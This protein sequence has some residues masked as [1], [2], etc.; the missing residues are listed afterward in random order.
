MCEAMSTW[1]QFMPSQENHG[2][3][4]KTWTQVTSVT[5][6]F[7]FKPTIIDKGGAGH[8]LTITTGTLLWFCCFDSVLQRPYSLPAADI[9]NNSSI[10]PGNSTIMK[11]T[12][13]PCTQ[14]EF[15]TC[16][17]EDANG[18]NPFSEIPPHSCRLQSSY[19]ARVGHTDPSVQD[20][21]TG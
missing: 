20:I 18:R 13:I 15:Q 4:W 16:Q 8:D 14:K 10:S 6:E 9:I 7:C 17:E 1:P 2:W 19:I 12:V 11:Y 3:R 5:E 21:C